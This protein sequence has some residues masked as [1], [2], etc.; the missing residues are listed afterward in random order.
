MTYAVFET[1]LVS[2][3][4]GEDVILQRADALLCHMLSVLALAL[5]CC[6][7]VRVILQRVEALGGMCPCEFPSLDWAGT[8]A[9]RQFAWRIMNDVW[10]TVA[11]F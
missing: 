3:A 6:W 4:R 5:I 10:R 8:T 9:R 7:N 11:K 2:C 1:V